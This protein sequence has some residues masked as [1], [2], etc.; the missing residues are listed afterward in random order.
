MDLKNSEFTEVSV[1]AIEID[2]D[3]KNLLDDLPHFEAGCR[4]MSENNIYKANEEFNKIAE[5]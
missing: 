2:T 4:Y 5:Y 3:L 1:T